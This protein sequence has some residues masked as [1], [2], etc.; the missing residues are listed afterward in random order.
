MSHQRIKSGNHLLFVTEPGG[1]IVRSGKPVEVTEDLSEGIQVQPFY[2]IRIVGGNRV[3]SEGAVTFK[4]IMKINRVSFLVLDTL[5][6]E[7][8]EQFTRTY[9]VPG[10]MLAIKAE[11]EHGAGLNAVDVAV[12]GYKF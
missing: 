5:T 10:L 9:D 7:P 3:I 4:L 1:H 11:G 12:F 6:L 8:G 2:T